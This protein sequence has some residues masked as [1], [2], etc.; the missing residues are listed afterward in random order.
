MPQQLDY[1]QPGPRP[2]MIR[3]SIVWM[4]ILTLTAPAIAVLTADVAPRPIPG[5]TLPTP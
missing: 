5:A 2:P 3:R 4:L 1:E